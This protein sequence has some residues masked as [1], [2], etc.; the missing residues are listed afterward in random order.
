MS[1]LFQS[2]SSGPNGHSGETPR[3]MRNYAWA[4]GGL[5]LA[6]LV[7]WLSASGNHERAGV[8]A[9][10]EAPSAVAEVVAVA[11]H[12]ESVEVIATVVA[13]A[14]TE[15]TKTVSIPAAQPIVE[16]T[17]DLAQ[18]ATFKNWLAEWENGRG[19]LQRGL[20]IARARKATMQ[21]IIQKDPEHAYQY[22][23]EEA[24]WIKLPESLKREVE[25]RFSGAGKYAFTQDCE[26]KASWH[27]LTMKD[28]STSNAVVAP[29]LLARQ[30]FEGEIKGVVLGEGGITGVVAMEGG[31][32]QG[33]QASTA[34]AA[35]GT[36]TGT[37]PVLWLNVKFSDETAWASTDSSAATVLS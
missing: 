10:G 34:P 4:S 27:Q 7:L 20:E 18:L 6:S 14:K 17:E 31:T 30:S 5:A 35:D 2:N 13:P 3:R 26:S 24:V 22:A 15:E 8:L 28:F 33:M 32:I 21:R 11:P 1:S 9:P 37:F 19:D 16:S 29:K 25:H 23:M 12:V 36:V